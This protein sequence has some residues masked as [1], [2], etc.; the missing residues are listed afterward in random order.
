MNAAYLI[1]QGTV[2]ALIVGLED[3]PASAEEL[4]RMSALVADGIEQGAVGLSS[5][6]TYT[7]GMYADD[8]ELTALCRVVAA[9]GGY[10]AR[11]TAPTARARWT[12]TPR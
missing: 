8:A 9:Y 4:A 12:P 10:Y 1:P 2:R 6:L 11:I 5:G 3:R 7:P